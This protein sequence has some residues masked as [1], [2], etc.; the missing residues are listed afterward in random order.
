[1]SWL[2][3]DGEVLAA[4]EI[5]DGWRARTRGLLGRESIDG[6]LIL[7]PCR[8]VHT[9]GVRFPIDVAFCQRD[10][11]VLHTASLR[12][13]RISRPVLRAAFAVE[14]ESGAIDRWRLRAGDVVE[15]TGLFEDEP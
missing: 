12:P 11:R 4:V 15:V 13:W 5:A 8:Q 7:V 10:G 1:M 14:A 2:V 6:A 3:R 9:L